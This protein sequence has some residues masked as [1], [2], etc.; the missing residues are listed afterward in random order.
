MRVMAGKAEMALR[1][2]GKAEMPGSSPGTSS[3]PDARLE[4]APAS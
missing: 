4:R 2:F 3:G 1:R